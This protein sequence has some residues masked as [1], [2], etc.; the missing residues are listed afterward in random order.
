MKTLGLKDSCFLLIL[1]A[2]ISYNSYGQGCTLFGDTTTIESIEPDKWIIDTSILNKY[3]DKEICVV[4]YNLYHSFKTVY[5][6]YS[7][8]HDKIELD[9]YKNNMLIINLAMP[10]SIHAM[11]DDFFLND[12]CT[13]YSFFSD[14]FDRNFYDCLF[15]KYYHKNF[16]VFPN[17]TYLINNLECIKEKN[18]N[19]YNL[20]TGIFDMIEIVP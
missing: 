19:L 11:I 14:N 2:L 13:T 17:G 4:Y 20:L 18:I 3:S 8:S 10:D 16:G 6:I 15:I 5:F 7:N 1:F 12:K 9:Q